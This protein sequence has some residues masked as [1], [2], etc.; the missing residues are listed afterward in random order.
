[1]LLSVLFTSLIT[2]MMLC[3]RDMILLCLSLTIRLHYDPTLPP[4]LTNDVIE[5]MATL[6]RLKKGKKFEDYKKQR[7]SIKSLVLAAKKS[8]FDKLIESDRSAATILKVINEITNKSRQKSK[9]SPT[10]SS[11]DSL[12]FF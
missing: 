5:A 2:L 3:P 12:T 4:W 11:P 8:Y 6:D 7:N 1:M 9:M 10:A